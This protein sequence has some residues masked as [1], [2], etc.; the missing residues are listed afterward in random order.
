[1]TRER[2]AIGLRVKTARATAIAV[3]GTAQ[4][5]RVLERR[6]LTLYDPDVPHSG[7]PYHLELELPAKQAA[8]LLERA[9]EAVRAAGAREL[10]SLVE[11]LAAPGREV[12]AVGLVAGS[13]GDPEKLGNPHV[14]AHARE[15]QLYWKVLDAAAESLG[16]GCS[17]VT[18]K[19]IWAHAAKSLGRKPD[20]LRGT[21]A[22]WGRE[23]GRPWGAEEKCAALAAW[24]ALR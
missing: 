11:S 15:G 19:E 7:Q 1:M 2:V 8:P 5:P 24:V 6:E 3:T 17:V 4:K 12:R 10:R 23:L 18:E 20:A 13:L 22:E 9:L 16:V 21:L 14:R